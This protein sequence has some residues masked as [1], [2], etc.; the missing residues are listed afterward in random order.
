MLVLV[1]YGVFEGLT[2]LLMRY[3][4]VSHY[5][6][7]LFGPFALGYMTSIFRFIIACGDKSSKK[8]ALSWSFRCGVIVTFLSSV[9]NEVFED[10]ATNGIPFLEAWHHLAADI[11]GLFTFIVGYIAWSL[12]QQTRA[13]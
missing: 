5:L 3:Y 11:L 7:G 8:W 13:Q 12:F 2:G 10:P 6:F 9:E 1:A 4:I